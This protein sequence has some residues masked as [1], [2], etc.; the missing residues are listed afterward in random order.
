MKILYWRLSVLMLI[1]VIIVSGCSKDEDTTPVTTG[2]LTGIVTDA[3]TS[4]VVS[5]VNVIVFDANT[6]APTGTT[7]VTDGSGVFTAE[8]EPG[9]YFIKASKQNYERLPQTGISPISFTISLGTTLQNDIELFQSSV[10]GGGWITGRVTD[11]TDALSGVLVVA[12][13]DL[14]AFSSVSDENGDFSIFNV[15]T[16]S[17]QIKGLQAGYNTAI[18][19]VSVSSNVE[20]AG[21]DITLTQGAAGSVTGQI[22]FLATDNI[23]VDVALLHPITRET[24]PGLTTNTTGGAYTISNVPDGTY[25][26]KATFENDTKVMDPDWIAKFGE[27]VVTVAGGAV[28]RD[29]S[30]TGAIEIVSPTNESTTTVPM[31]V[32]TTAPVFEWLASPST[33]DYVIEVVDGSGKLIW[34]GFSSEFTVKNVVIPSDILSVTFGDTNYGDAP[35][36]D[37]IPGKVYRWRVYASKN[38]QNSATGWTLISA[39]EDQRGLMS[40]TQ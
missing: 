37:L 23:E 18:V 6:N 30:V 15:A 33:T 25:L 11:G 29:F 27:P 36:E 20:T 28:T 12:G 5:G 9:S 14:A 4:S 13:T 21:A 24:I 19:D 17:Y 16:G 34:G 10:T 8:L 38:D 40:I 22:T 1:G 7:L 3:Y 31:D 26:S 2:T 39:S 35:I 32:A